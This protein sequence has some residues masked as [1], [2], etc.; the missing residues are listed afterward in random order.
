[1]F[2]PDYTQQTRRAGDI[3]STA[4]FITFL[5]MCYIRAAMDEAVAGTPL[6]LEYMH[7]CPCPLEGW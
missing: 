1:M 7:N 5:H 4:W 6:F 3:K 2:V